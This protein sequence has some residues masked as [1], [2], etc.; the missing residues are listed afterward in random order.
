MSGVHRTVRCAHHQQLLQ[1]LQNWMVAINT[2]PTGHFEVWESKQHS[3][4]SRWHTKTLPTTYI[5]WYNLYTRSSPLQPTQVPQKRE[6]AIESY[7]IEF[8]PSALWDTLRDIVCFILVF[9]CAWSFD[10]HSNFLQKCWR[11]VK[12]SKRHQRVWWSLWDREWSLRRRRDHRSLCDRGREG[13]GWK[14]PVLKWTPQ[15]GLGL[16]GPNLGKTNHP[17][18]LFLLLVICLFS[19]A[20]GFLAPLFAN[21]IWC[22][23][24]LNSHLVKQHVARKNL[25]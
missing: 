12:A 3:K 24:K 11:L 15:R 13:K 5:H 20:L 8:S 17:C 21:I 10:S 16:R 23:L 25:F 4:S 14:R 6:R 22:C 9:I 2:T 1:R 18:P 7:S 19:L